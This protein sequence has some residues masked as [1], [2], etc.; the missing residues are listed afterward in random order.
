MKWRIAYALAVLMIAASLTVLAVGS[1]E[2]ATIIVDDDWAGAD[3]STIEEAL[4]R[5]GS[6]DTIEVYDGTYQENINVTE[7]I[8]II[9]NGSVNTTIDGS[10]DIAVKLFSNNVTLSG[11]NFTNAS[12]GVITDASGFTI[13]ANTF[14]HPIYG[15]YWEYYASPYGRNPGGDHTFYEVVV[16]GN[17]FIMNSNSDAIYVKLTANYYGAGPYDLAYEDMTFSDNV[18]HMNGTTAKGIRI[19]DISAHELVGG[20]VSIGD[21]S[22]EQNTFYG[23]NNGVNFFGTC[24]ELNDTSVTVGN[25]SMI[26]NEAY[27]QA[28]SAFYIDYYDFTFNVGNTTGTYGD[29]VCRDNVVNSSVQY[30]DA[31]YVSD[32]AYWEYC[33]DNVSLTVGDVFVEG[34][35]F[36]VDEDGYYADYAEILYYCYDNV[37]V[38]MGDTYVRNNTM[39]NVNNGV[40]LYIEFFEGSDD[41][42]SLVVGDVF[43]H[44]NNINASGTAIEYA[45]YEFGY[46]TLGNSSV[47]FGDIFIEDNILNTNWNAIYFYYDDYVPNYMYEYS[48]AYLG[49]VYILNNEITTGT[50]E[51]IFVETYDDS[52]GYEMQDNSILELHD[53][54]VRGNNITSDGV[55]FKFKLYD[56]PYQMSGNSSIYLGSFTIDNNEFDCGSDAIYIEFSYLCYPTYDDAQ[57]EIGDIVITNNN[58]TSA[59]DAVYLYIADTYEAYDRTNL[60]IGNITVT[61]NE[62]FSAS[63]GFE[64]EI[65]LDVDDSVNLTAGTTTISRNV[66]HDVL[67]GIYL[68]YTYYI[69]NDWEHQTGPLICTDNIIYNCTTDGIRIARIEG[70]TGSGSTTNPSGNVSGNQVTNCGNRGIYIDGLD[71]YIISDNNCSFSDQHGMYITATSNATFDGNEVTNNTWNG[72]NMESCYDNEVMNSVV[73]YNNLIEDSNGAGIYIG[74]SARISLTRSLVSRNPIFG[75]NLDN[76]NNVTLHMNDILFNC[77]GE[78]GLNLN[79]ADYCIISWNNISNSTGAGVEMSDSDHSTFH[80]NTMLGN[81]MNGASSSCIHVGGSDWTTVTDN[82]IHYTNSGEGII[83]LYS[84]NC[85]ITFNDVGFNNHGMVIEGGQ[86]NLIQNNSIYRSMNF[87]VYLYEAKNNTIIYN[88]IYNNSKYGAYIVVNSVNNTIHHNNLYSNGDGTSQGMD[89]SSDGNTWDNGTHGNYWNDYNGTDGNGDGVGDTAYELDGASN[90]DDY[91]LTNATG[92]DVPVPVPE[93]AMIPVM[94]FVA[95]LF[96]AVA[97][98]RRHQR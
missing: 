28:Q 51:A 31:L 16:E 17:E 6:G 7:E 81:N 36:D 60:T 15:I 83:I 59:A 76:V 54:I 52:L 9:G 80:N 10:G 88:E 70:G 27:E 47:R 3:Y 45:Y 82:K 67:L 75:V 32:L 24:D 97:V 56:E 50:N 73:F 2:G 96:F 74:T 55:G 22:F 72:I 38:T 29:L 61:G 71:G 62:V 1:S 4:N 40:Y 77:G 68:R 43:I 87:G 90:T 37:T 33:E 48:S 58:I 92:N 5:S 12:A 63:W 95:T 44:D 23:G 26:G 57:V 8:A 34:N 39:H 20:N 89:T 35:Y 46:N 11:F 42:A 19:L 98:R 78:A 25:L 69:N 65:S 41:N 21:V 66:V 13:S 85:T 53:F 86:F 79:Q 49:D 94:M 84:D 30:S 18:F 91:P 93:M 14:H 64:I